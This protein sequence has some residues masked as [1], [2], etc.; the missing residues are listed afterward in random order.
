MN[1]GD[2]GARLLVR[3]FGGEW[4]P[5]SVTSYST[6]AHLQSVLGSQPSL[7]PGV[8]ASPVAVREI[9][10]GSGPLDVLVIDVDGQIT[11]VECK[12]ASNS[13]IRRE[14]VGQ[15]LDYAS[16][17]WRM[18]FDDLDSRWRQRHPDQLG[19]LDA[20]D[21]DGE[22]ASSVATAIEQNLAA[23]RFNVVL[24]VDVINNGLRRIVEFLNDRTASD[25]S[26]VA[27]QLRYARHDDV[28]ILV[29]TVYGSELAQVKAAKAGAQSAWSEGDVHAYLEQHWPEAA[30]PV[31]AIVDAIRD[32]P[33][34][35]FV[36]TRATTP[37]MICRWDTPDGAAWPFVIYT[38]KKPH[39]RMNFHWMTSLPEGLKQQ[40]AMDLALIANS[41]IDPAAIAESGFKKK[42][43]MFILDCL[44]APAAQHGFIAA[45]TTAVASMKTTGRV[46]DNREMPTVGG[47]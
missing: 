2:A 31:A 42:P 26:I 27:I 7:L 40:L 22:E 28:E 36:G 1:Q 3:T 6:E 30:A 38:S 37:S 44:T 23:G 21:L 5:P 4:A 35:S 19:I 33:G 9:Q 39:V 45:M 8:G 11:L 32:L 12:L 18:S 20:L 24:A 43:S 17:L 16:S 25:L 14:I 10:T 15:V 46:Q 47:Y 41:G 29:P 34:I 13:E